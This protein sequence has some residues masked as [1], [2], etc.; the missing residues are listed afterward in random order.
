MLVEGLDLGHSISFQQIFRHDPL[1]FGLW[2]VSP[3]ISSP[4]KFER[5]QLYGFSNMEVQNIGL[6]A[7]F[8]VPQ[9]G[10]LGVFIVSYSA[11]CKH[12]EW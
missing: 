6:F 1:R 11:M 9:T 4:M 2:V 3:D 7:I 10:V 8:N 5:H 12:M